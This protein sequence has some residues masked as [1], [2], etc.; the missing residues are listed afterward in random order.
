MSKKNRNVQEDW[1]STWAELVCNGDGSLNKEAIMNE[2]SDFSM[3]IDNLSK[4]YYE[5]TGGTASKP[6]TDAEVIIRLYGEELGNEYDRGYEDALDDHGIFRGS[7][8]K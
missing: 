8:F 5:M 1:N 3:L 2:L 7:N 6:N 4:I